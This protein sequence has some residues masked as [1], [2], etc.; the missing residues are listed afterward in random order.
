M[1]GLGFRLRTLIG[2]VAVAAL[3]MAWENARRRAEACEREAARHER[4]AAQYAQQASRRGYL[5]GGYPLETLEMWAL[6]KENAGR[7]AAYH[8][9]EAGRFRLAARRPWATMPRDMERAEEYRKRSERYRYQAGHLAGQSRRDGLLYKKFEDYFDRGFTT[10]PDPE[11]VAYIQRPQPRDPKIWLR[12][13]A[14]KLR[15]ADKSRAEAA[16]LAMLSRFY[17]EAAGALSSRP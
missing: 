6:E 11:G 1:H 12:L 3:P 2:L 17:D 7:W 4:L 16:E 9:A 13:A 8:S 5:C 15:D 14:G 10:I